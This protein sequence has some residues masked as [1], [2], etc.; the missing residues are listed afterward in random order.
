MQTKTISQLI[1][2]LAH[3]NQLAA[4]R[5]KLETISMF[6]AS[7]TWVERKRTQGELGNVDV[8]WAKF[9]SDHSNLIGSNAFQQLLE[10]DIFSYVHSQVPKGYKGSLSRTGQPDMVEL[11]NALQNDYNTV[12]VEIEKNKNVSAAGATELHSS[13]TKEKR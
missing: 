4:K 8:D 5:R 1:Q 13:K 2:A 9:Q 12:L 11:A 3:C 10:K 6:M 7:L